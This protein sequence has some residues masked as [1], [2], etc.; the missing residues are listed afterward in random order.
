MVKELGDSLMMTTPE[1]EMEDVLRVG[2]PGKKEAD[3]EMADFRQ[4]QG[5]KR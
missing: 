3:E 1:R 5:D 2:R 4:G